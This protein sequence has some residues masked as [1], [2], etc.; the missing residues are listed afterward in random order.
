MPINSMFVLALMAEINPNEFESG[1]H[2]ELTACDEFN[3]FEEV[4]H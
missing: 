2:D 4:M 3:V 1:P